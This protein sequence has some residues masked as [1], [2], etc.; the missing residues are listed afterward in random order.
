MLEEYQRRQRLAADLNLQLRRDDE[1]PSQLYLCY[2]P[3]LPSGAAEQLGCEV[4]LRWQHPQL[5]YISPLEIVEVAESHGLG[6][7][8]GDWIFGCLNRDLAC[9]PATLLARLEVAVNLSASQ[10][11]ADLPDRIE[12]YLRNGPLP[13]PQLVLEL[14]ETIAL[15]DFQLSQ[16][17]VQALTDKQ[18]RVALDDFGTGW[19]SLSYLRELR[20]DKLK[21]DKSFIQG[22]DHDHRQQVFVRSITELAHNLGVK[23]VAEGVETRDEQTAVGR[24]GV[25]E[26]QGYYHA[27]P[28]RLAAFAEFAGQYLH[29]GPEARQQK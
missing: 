2:Q 22:I 19:S 5:G 4:L 3:I 15:K 17:I 6:S 1:E 18:I 26:V 7:A 12:Q 28:L 11:H 24:M 8:L 9:L 13:A 10:F 20:V 29:T 25:N 16:R 21:I 27:R 14:T 23:V